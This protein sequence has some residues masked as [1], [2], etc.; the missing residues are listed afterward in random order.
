M[1]QLTDPYTAP[2]GR[3]IVLRCKSKFIHGTDLMQRLGS[4]FQ[5]ENF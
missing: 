1:N 2:H 3:L 4:I 5:E